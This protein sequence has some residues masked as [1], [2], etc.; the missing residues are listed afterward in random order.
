MAELTPQE[1]LQPSLLD[2]LTDTDPHRQRESRDARVLSVKQLREG[3]IRDLVWLL[4]TAS[5]T[6]SQDL[7]DFPE[8][9]SSVLNYGMP[10]LSGS[11]CSSVSANDIERQIRQAIANFEPRIL[12]NSIRVKVHISEDMMNHNAIAIEIH[13]DLW[14]Q[15]MPEQ[16]FLKT[17]VDLETGHVRIAEHTGEGLY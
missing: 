6:T 11:T 8:V 2:R 17:E 5:M 9:E 12:A 14:A 13:G 4:N 1:R 3:V 7:E 10:H 16:L 15:P